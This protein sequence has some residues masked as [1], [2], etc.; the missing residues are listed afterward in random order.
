[1]RRVVH[2]YVHSGALVVFQVIDNLNAPGRKTKNNSPIRPH[3]RRPN[4]SAIASELRQSP[5]ECRQIN[6]RGCSVAHGELQTQLFALTGND[7]GLATRSVK[8]FGP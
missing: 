1:M 4:F 5:C 2:R 3:G 8:R 6:G 7:S